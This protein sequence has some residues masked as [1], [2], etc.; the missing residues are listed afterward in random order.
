[1]DHNKNFKTLKIGYFADGPWSHRSFL[2]IISNKQL[3]I[4]FIVPRQ[5][6]KDKTLKK[7]CKEY[8]IDYLPNSNV[9]SEKFIKQIIE[10]NVDLFVSMS[11]NQI[12]KKNI[13]SIP[14]L[15]VIN[16]HAGKLPFYRG[17]NVLNWVLIN[18]EKNFGITVHYIDENIDTG[19][20]IEQRIF[21]ISEDDN[22]STILE[23]AYKNCPLILYESIL[24]ILNNNVKTTKQ[25]D[26]HHKGSY[27]RKRKV[28]DIKVDGGS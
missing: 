22:Y 8:E 13:I 4:S 11:F 24:K 25:N 1:M 10:Y 7:F 27:C 16:C 18:G 12:F 20:I 2:K 17:R 9:N 21:P 15:G 6:T 3:I 5:N 14:K 28:G 19:D 26:I 23:T